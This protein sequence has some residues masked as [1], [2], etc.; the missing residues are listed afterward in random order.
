MW[1]EKLLR[2]QG[3][4]CDWK[5]VIVKREISHW[6]GNGRKMTSHSNFKLKF[7]K[8]FW[9]VITGFMF[10]VGVIWEAWFPGVI[11]QLKVDYLKRSNITLAGQ[12]R[13]NDVTEQIQINDFWKGFG[14]KL[15]IFCSDLVWF[16]KS[17]IGD[18]KRRSIILAWE[19]QK[20]KVTKQLQ[21]NIF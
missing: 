11:I 7:F 2:F 15:D 18:H 5:L 4:S 9:D 20:D 14:R 16:E 12:R 13:K 3:Y 21:T 17:K 10:Q 8:R 19:Q 6:Q 1:F